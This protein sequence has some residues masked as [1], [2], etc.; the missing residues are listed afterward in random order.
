[1][2]R[3]RFL[4]IA[5]I[6]LVALAASAQTAANAPTTSGPQATSGSASATEQH[7]QMLTQKLDLTAD[8][9]TK[10]R[11]IVEHMLSERQ[12]LIDDTSLSPETRDQKL[13]ALHEQAKKQARKYLNDDQ[14]KKFDDLKPPH[15]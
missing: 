10:I 6:L 15:H 9:Q 3:F 8:Q 14:K 5:S 7:V 11:P 1:M 12:K 2:N 4:A 13:K